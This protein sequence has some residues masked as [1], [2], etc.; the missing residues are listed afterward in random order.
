MSVKELALLFICEACEINTRNEIVSQKKRGK[1]L[2]TKIWQEKVK[3][4]NSKGLP[5]PC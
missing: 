5:I 2:D 3:E 1:L 4:I